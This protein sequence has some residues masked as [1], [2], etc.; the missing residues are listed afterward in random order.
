M[1]LGLK[2]KSDR[3]GRL[4]YS[5]SRLW[6]LLFAA[7]AL[8]EGCALLFGAIFEGEARAVDGRDWPSLL[9]EAILIFAALYEESWVFDKEAGTLEGRSGLVFAFRRRRLPLS[10][11]SSFR[12][13][14]FAKGRQGPQRDEGLLG[15]AKRSLS[16]SWARLVAFDSR[17]EP[18][19]I[20]VVNGGKIGALR[21]AGKAMADYCGIPIEDGD[22][23]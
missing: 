10:S 14:S 13:E 15:G 23:P 5:I 16:R 11:L 7:L 3:K 18:K 19:V 4:V 9:V 21:K 17:G 2:L 12:I 1:V 8:L 6:R 20:D 22:L